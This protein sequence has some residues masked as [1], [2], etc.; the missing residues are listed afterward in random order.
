[1]PTKN[2]PVVAVATT[3]LHPNSC[4]I[5][6]SVELDAEDAYVTE[7]V[8]NDS[9][10]STKILYPLDQVFGFDGSSSPKET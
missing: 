10:I 4:M 6:L 1:M 8:R 7:S 3:S 9:C 2:I 5:A